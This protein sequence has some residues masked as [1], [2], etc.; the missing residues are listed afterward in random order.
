MITNQIKFAIYFIVFGCLCGVQILSAQVLSTS[1]QPDINH[2]GKLPEY[3]SLAISPDGKHYALIQRQA[4]QD[5]F[6]IL[7][8]ETLEMVGGFNADKFKAR[9]IHFVSNEH[10]VLESSKH[11][12]MMQVRGSWENSSAFVYNLTSKKIKTLLSSS[13]GLYPAQGG[14]GRIVGFNKKTSELYMPAFAG[15]LGATPKYHL[16][17]VSLEHGRGKV[18]AKGKAS[19]IDWFVDQ[20]GKVLARED[21]NKSTQEHQIYSKVTGS[22]QVI[23]SNETSIPD[24]SLQALSRDGSSLLF[25]AG[26]DNNEAVFSMSLNDGAVQGPLYVRKD[27]DIG[28]LQTDINQTLIAVMYSGF[29]PDYEFSTAKDNDSYSIL[30]NHF[31]SSS[32]SFHGNTA[33]N[34][35]W[36]IR[37]SG[38]EGASVYKVFDRVQTKLY[39][40]VSEYPSI[41]SIGEL[42]AVNL[43]ARDGMKIPS[44]ITLPT[45]SSKR[46]NLPLIALP[47]GGPAAHDSLRFD[48]LAQYLAAKGYAVLQPNFRGSTGFGSA[49]RDSGDGEW[50]QKMQ[51][52][53]SDGVTALAKAGYIDPERVCIMG[54][55]YGGYSAL[56]GGAFTPDLYRCVISIAGVS[57]LPQMLST[58]KSK[59]GRDH[60]VLSYLENIIGDPNSQREK[61]KAI[62]PINFADSFQAP[63]LLIHG[64]D[65]TVVPI[66]QSKAMYKALQKAD[67]LVEFVTLKGEDHWLSGSETRLALLKAVDKFLD[68]HNPA[69]TL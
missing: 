50:G 58:E 56:A 64:K 55:S 8:A 49:L 59:Y 21:Y 6:V 25:I 69:E 67:K 60:W 11:T 30:A 52:D 13:K 16:Y 35:K 22:W 26:Y 42:K 24:I 27:T 9:G 2:Y 4:N 32:V 34:N 7:N 1:G 5:F 15:R 41:K 48:W 68:Q 40:L 43:S 17:R 28:Y 18:H 62:S 14:L 20:T 45:D 47:H 54:A 19:T 37:V 29:T 61:L 66:K 12:R 38:N 36:L 44:I 10:V 31:S 65:D 63:V 3:R 53:V 23:Y 46:K 51:D 39:N 33:D 57:D